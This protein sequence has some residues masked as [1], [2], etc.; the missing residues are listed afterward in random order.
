M[1]KKIIV[2]F[3]FSFF[4]MI[5]VGVADYY[6]LG[7]S[8]IMKGIEVGEFKDIEKNKE[9]ILKLSIARMLLAL[10][11]FA[12][13][14]SVLLT[15]YIFKESDS[16]G[17]LTGLNFKVDLNHILLAI[18]IPLAISILT[19]L[20]NIVLIKLGFLKVESSNLEKVLSFLNFKNILIQFVFII[21]AG[22]SLNALFAFGE[23]AGWRGY[24]VYLLR[25]QNFWTATMVIGILWGFW[26]SPVIYLLGYN[27]GTSNNIIGIFVMM[28]FTVSLTPWMLY[29]RLKS[30]SSIVPAIF[31]GVLNASAGY[32]TLLGGDPI[33]TS[34][35]GIFG[36]VIINLFNIPLF[37]SRETRKKLEEIF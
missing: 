30:G 22:I 11:M 9:M 6:I 7:G 12:P 14:I 2:F 3:V 8:D 34:V 27:Y 4:L 13:F 36:I 26:H 15:K 28:L 33:I 37:I 16:I 20:V 1:V 18:L 21:I 23:E 17:K 19:F 35:A 24:L 29:L 32:S 31:H 10:A 5:T 25:Q